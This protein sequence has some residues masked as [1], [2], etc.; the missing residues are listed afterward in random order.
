MDLY[1]PHIVLKFQINILKGFW[2]IAIYVFL[3]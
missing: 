1:V 2:I 3:P